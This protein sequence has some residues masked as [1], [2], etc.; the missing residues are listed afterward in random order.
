MDSWD[1]P[2]QVPELSAWAGLTIESELP[3]GNRNRVLKASLDG[4]WVVVRHSDHSDGSLMWEL[5]LLRYLQGRG[6]PV[7]RIIATDQGQLHA[8][9]WS[10]QSFVEGRRASVP[11]DAPVMV[12]TFR[13]I[14]RATAGW[15][16]R[17]GARSASE[18]L[19]GARGEDIDLTV[20]PA[21]LAAAIRQ[22]WRLVGPRGAGVVHGDP[23]LDNILVTDDDSCVVIDWDE[24]RVDDPG[25]DLADI[26][27]A[28]SGRDWCRA[29]EAWEIAACWRAE[30]QYAASLVPGFMG[31]P[32]D[33]PSS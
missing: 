14:H 9:G 18:L 22:A 6:I 26:D 19:A 29:A 4:R 21:G 16:Q 33:E 15:P 20:M 12:E 10:V 24:A 5:R 3:G 31:A 11:G 1:C 30:P 7:P 27:P 28:G 8:G 13:R 25:F 2:G 32:E 17:P 23:G